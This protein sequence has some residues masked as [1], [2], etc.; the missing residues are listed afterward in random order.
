[1]TETE[2]L[3]AQ[4]QRYRET[5]ARYGQHDASCTRAPCSCGF[6][7]AWAA[8]G[9]MPQPDPSEHSSAEPEE[10]LIGSWPVMTRVCETCG[11][12]SL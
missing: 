11:R 9:K 1:M 4:V 8:A 10:K 12:H 2:R 3:T 7:R 5:L 6:L